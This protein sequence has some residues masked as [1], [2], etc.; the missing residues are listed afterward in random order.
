MLES[1]FPIEATVDEMVEIHAQMQ[2]TA[3]SVG[4]FTAI[5][6]LIILSIDLLSAACLIF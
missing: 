6:A 4:T 2:I 3:R 5:P 1:S